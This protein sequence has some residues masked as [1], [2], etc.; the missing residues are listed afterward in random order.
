MEY[1]TL[2]YINLLRFEVCVS[3]WQQKF[4]A[5]TDLAMVS[6]EPMLDNLQGGVSPSMDL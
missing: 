6:N 3:L 2:L 1:L 5:V 4:L